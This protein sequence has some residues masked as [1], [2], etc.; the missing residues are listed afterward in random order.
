MYFNP[1][2]RVWFRGAGDKSLD[3]QRNRRFDVY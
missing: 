3:Y 1:R 2:R